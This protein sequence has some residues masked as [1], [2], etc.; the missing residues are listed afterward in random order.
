MHCS[1]RSGQVKPHAK[2]GI[3]SPKTW[4]FWGFL[5]LYKLISKVNIGS[6]IEEKTNR[7]SFL[8]FVDTLDSIKEIKILPQVEVKLLVG[9]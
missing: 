6:E 2:R 7:C 9:V 5:K 3:E 4:G 8:P 1:G